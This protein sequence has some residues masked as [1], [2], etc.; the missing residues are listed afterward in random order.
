M[1]HASRAIAIS[2]QSASER[3]RLVHPEKLPIISTS[4]PSTHLARFPKHFVTRRRRA[5]CLC[6]EKLRN[7][8][9]Q[10]MS[11]F[12][13]DA[14]LRDNSKIKQRQS[15]QKSD[16]ETGVSVK[17]RRRCSFS[18]SQVKTL[19]AHFRK[20]RYLSTDQRA[21]L[22]KVLGLSEQQVKI[23][24]QNRR[25]KTKRRVMMEST[26]AVTPV[27]GGA[28]VPSKAVPKRPPL[29]VLIRDGE[30][31]GQYAQW[32]SLYY[33]MMMCFSNSFSANKGPSEEVEN[34]DVV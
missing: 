20:H 4:C 33:Y 16:V 14:L 3:R 23:W 13:V 26:S 27:E 28:C 9:L 1:H 11:A 25:Y 30:R 29:I 10:K 15:S 19:E 32:I 8:T 17:S 31:T 24:F 2:S 5:V 12:S 34:C 21:V 22:A 18:Q 7:I 6:R